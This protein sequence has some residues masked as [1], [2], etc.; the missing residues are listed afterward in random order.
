MDE[1]KRLQEHL[2]NRHEGDLAGR[3]RSAREVCRL[4]GHM[5]IFMGGFKPL[6]EDERNVREGWDLEATVICWACQR[7]CEQWQEVKLDREYPAGMT[8]DEVAKILK[9]WQHS[10]RQSGV[11][12]PL[13]AT[14]VTTFLPF[15]AF[16]MVSSQA[17]MPATMIGGIAPNIIDYD[18]LVRARGASLTRNQGMLPEF[19]R[20]LHELSHAELMDRIPGLTAAEAENLYDQL[21]LFYAPKDIILDDDPGEGPFVE[22]EEENSGTKL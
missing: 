17:T 19:S 3:Q 9:R 21:Q 20:A 12:D 22:A 2:A 7:C 14:Q 4:K 5:T 13:R 16:T 10:Y 18:D 1:R 6:A 15:G 8:R 11:I